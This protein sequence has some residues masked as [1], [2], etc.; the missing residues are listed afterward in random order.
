MEFGQAFNSAWELAKRGGWL[1]LVAAAM[2][3]GF[4]LHEHDARVRAK[5]A[6]EEEK[7]ATRAEVA[8]LKEQAAGELKTA[9]Q[10]DAEAVKRLKA[11]RRSLMKK[12]KK[13]AA[14]LAAIKTSEQARLK[15]IRA[16][17]LSAVESQLER[18]LGPE[19]EGWPGGCG[20]P[21]PTRTGGGNVHLRGQGTAAVAV[22]GRG[23]AAT[24]GDGSRGSAPLG[25]IVSQEARA[26]GEFFGGRA[27]VLSSEGARKVD[28]AFAELDAC[29]AERVNQS[30]QIQACAGRAA[31]DEAA[32]ARQADAVEKLNEALKTKGQAW[33]ARQAETRAELRSARGTFWQKLARTME[34]VAI[35]VG[36]GVVIGMA[37]R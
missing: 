24:A 15:E 37:A 25:A 8:R 4:W 19:V 26:G 12:E 14:S 10:R 5:A 11:E 2:L 30:Q 22:A 21:K 6:L 28:E 9:N 18:R 27:V 35:G 3:G 33:R 16:L 32:L 23:L 36:I 13:L 17:P 29:R 31:T 20:A 1:G 34:H 7:R